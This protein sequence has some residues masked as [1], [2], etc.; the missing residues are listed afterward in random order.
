MNKLKAMD[1]D[2]I[3]LEDVAKF[4]REEENNEIDKLDYE[5]KALPVLLVMN[6]VDLVVNKRKLRGLQDEL[7]DIGSFD[8]TFHVSCETGFGIEALRLYLKSQALRRP[9]QYHPDVSSTKSE[10]EKCEDVLKQ[11]I[12]SRFYREVPYETA[13]K[14]TSWVPMSNGELKI[15]FQIEVKYDVNAS[16]LVGRKGSVIGELRQELNKCLSNMYQLPVK[17]SLFVVLRRKGLS[18]EALNEMGVQNV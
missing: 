15:S 12:F 11:M 5:Q 16:M 2:D 10:L 6:K 3:S 14:V 18:V 7:E 13:V 9:W 17:S 1:L 4:Q 8:K